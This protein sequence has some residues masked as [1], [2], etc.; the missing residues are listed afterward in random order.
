MQHVRGPLNE[1]DLYA[2]VSKPSDTPD[3]V[4]STKQGEVKGQEEE[5]EDD[6]QVGVKWDGSIWILV[7]HV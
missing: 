6:V 2:V 5:E 4:Q 3:G 1:D 7:L